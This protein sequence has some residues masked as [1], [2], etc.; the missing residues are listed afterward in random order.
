[1]CVCVGQDDGGYK[2]TAAERII[3]AAR[4]KVRRRASGSGRTD[5]YYEVQLTISHGRST[6]HN[7][8]GPLKFPDPSRFGTY[9]RG[10]WGRVTAGCA[11]GRKNNTAIG[12]LYVGLVYDIY[13]YAIINT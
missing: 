5:H 3:V 6:R 13:A 9:F 10:G 2:T 4:T 1:M 12:R 7:T 11:N 8:P